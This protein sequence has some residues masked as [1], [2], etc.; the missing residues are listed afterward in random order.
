MIEADPI[1]RE[2]LFPY[3]IGRDL[4]EDGR[5]S[6]WI[7]DFGQRDMTEAMR[8]PIHPIDLFKD[9]PMLNRVYDM[10][11]EDLRKEFNHDFS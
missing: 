3:M 8:Y 5:P 7:I 1:N 4:V 2:V 9:L 10:I 11:R 6:R